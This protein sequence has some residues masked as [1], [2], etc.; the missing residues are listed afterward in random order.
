MKKLILLLCFLTLNLSADDPIYQWQGKYYQTDKE[1]E[2][3]NNVLV[4]KT[5]GKPVPETKN[6]VPSTKPACVT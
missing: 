1:V 5:T 2:T 3:K 6:E 4:F